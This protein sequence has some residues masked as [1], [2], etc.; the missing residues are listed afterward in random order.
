MTS[1]NADPFTLGV[2][3]SMAI[4]PVPRE[5]RLI[6]VLFLIHVKLPK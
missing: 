2:D 5:F 6:Q 4:Y 3:T 1:T